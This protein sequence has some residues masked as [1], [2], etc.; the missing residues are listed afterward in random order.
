MSLASDNSSMIS[1]E[2]IQAHSRSDKYT[3]TSEINNPPLTHDILQEMFGKDA[4]TCV[5]QSKKGLTLDKTQIDILNQS[6][7]CK[8]PVKI[9]A[10][11]D[12][13]KDSLPIRERAEQYLQDDLTEILLIKKLG[14]LS[15]L[16]RR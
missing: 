4:Q 7:H 14:S 5:S 10:Y 3:G 15:K 16:L 11:K 12:S 2:N 6:W 9:S 8:A 13:Y 1:T